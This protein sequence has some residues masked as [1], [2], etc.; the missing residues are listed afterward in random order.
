VP[1]GP[2]GA[3]GAADLQRFVVFHRHWRAS[4]R[5]ELTG[6]GPEPLPVIDSKWNLQIWQGFR[7]GPIPPA[8]SGAGLMPIPPTDFTADS[9][10][11][12]CM[13]GQFLS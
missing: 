3:S 13:R 6:K 4:E 2:A 7:T 11:A 10:A 5:I 8:A 9:P 1:R 12:I